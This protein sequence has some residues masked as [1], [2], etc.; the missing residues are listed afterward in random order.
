MGPAQHTVGRVMR[1]IQEEMKWELLNHPASSP[2]FKPLDREVFQKIKLPDKGRRF[3]NS[4]ELK[5]VV[6]QTVDN[7]NDDHSLI[8]TT[9][10][11]LNRICQR[12]LLLRQS[13]KFELKWGWNFRIF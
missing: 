1:F 4:H 9:N 13:L 11:G 12:Q 5:M 3:E 7:I 2:N 8:E 6:R 10:M